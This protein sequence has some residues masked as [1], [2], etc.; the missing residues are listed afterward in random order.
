[1][2]VLGRWDISVYPASWISGLCFVHSDGYH[3]IASRRGRNL[4]YYG[5]LGLVL[6]ARRAVPAVPAVPGQ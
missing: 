4:P 5:V 1:M 3:G 2:R 6:W